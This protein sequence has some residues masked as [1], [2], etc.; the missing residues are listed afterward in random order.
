MGG[1]LFWVGGTDTWNST[2]GLK[3]SYT[4]GGIGGAPA[5]TANDI[6]VF[7]LFSGGG[8]VT[9]SNTAV[10]NTV[11][12]IGFGGTITHPAGT[13]WTISGGLYFCSSMT[14]NASSSGTSRV[15]F[16]ATC[17]LPYTIFTAGQTMGITELN[18]AGGGWVLGDDFTS[19]SGSIDF[20]VIQGSF[21]TGNFDMTVGG[22]D[23]TGTDT[24]SVTLGNS[25]ITLFGET[26]A[27][28]WDATDT[29]G[30][31]FDAGTSTINLVG[32]EF[33]GGGLDYYNVTVSSRQADRRFSGENTFV[34]LTVT[35][36][37]AVD[38]DFKFYD[39]MTITG[40]LT[41]TGNSVVNKFIIQSDIYG[42][43]RT[44][45]AANVVATNVHFQDIVGDGA[46]SWDFSAQDDVGDG[47]GNTGI[48][49]P[50]AINVYWVGNG[51][52]WTTTTKWASSSG[53]SGGSGRYP[54]PQDTAVFDSNSISS[55]GEFVTVNPRHVCN[56]DAS[57]VTND[58]NFTD[59]NGEV[60]Y[61]DFINGGAGWSGDFSA[62][63]VTFQGRGTHS[64]SIAGDWNNVGL[65]F[66]ALGGSYT[67]DS[68]FAE[69]GSS[70]TATMAITSGT[71]DF[72]DYDITFP[73]FSIGAAAI[74]SMGTG[75]ITAYGTSTP[76]AVNA[77]ATLNA[78]TS[79]LAITNTGTVTFSGA[80]KTYSTV[81]LR[82][83]ANTIT[84]NGSNTFSAALT[85]T[86]P[87]VLRFE[88]NSTQTITPT[89]GFNMIG[90]A[91]NII[92]MN[93]V[94]SGVFT[95]SSANNQTIDYC[96][97]ANCTGSGGGTFTATNSTDGG[98]NTN[99][100]I[101]P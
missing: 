35:G 89:N 84:V 71:I 54:L 76:W 88:N 83:S 59:F 4:S 97:L 28:L 37:S 56:I 51:G 25:E 31:T 67:F 3:W 70:T 47:W 57:I 11:V 52:N 23:M 34:N 93:R 5:P 68:D 40:T 90:S 50:A 74:L 22:F 36:L 79:T 24:R 96:T 43:Q 55:A 18:G 92:N 77:S 73:R 1:I 78:E 17:A 39:D 91:G 13:I 72:N 69:D 46:A 7:D 101:T 82:T 81:T 16:N 44:I 63:F 29:T 12:C 45:T 26:A 6:V 49:F 61:G 87:A 21:D 20:R 38:S 62:G 60:F 19:L 65:V 33:V 80:G 66:D 14:Y 15:L 85:A 27:T 64:I 41:F 8:T 75:T 32:H 100:T 86:A 30:L 42:T 94:S 2:A 99:W 48:T 98:G 95:I 58:P 9:L 10:C 53:G